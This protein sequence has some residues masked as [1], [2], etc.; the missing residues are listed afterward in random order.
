[1]PPSG[2]TVSRLLGLLYEA[3]ASTRPWST[4]LAAL[5]N[6]TGSAASY[7][8]ILDPQGKC[9]VNLNQGFDP[10]WTHA[11]MTHFNQHD[12]VLS[13]YLAAKRLHGEWIGTRESVIPAEEYFRS[14]IHNEFTKPQGKRYSCAAALGGLDGILDGGL[15]LMRG[16]ADKPFG[17]ETVTLL[18]MLAPH[19]KQA[20]NT[21]RALGLAHC[22]NAE[23][24]ESV[25]ALNLAVL[26]LDKT[27]RVVRMSAAAQAIL[28]LR[29]GIVLDGGFL[30]ASVA[31]EQSQLAAMIAGAV[32][33]GV[34]HG[35]EVAVRRKTST[36]P[37]AGDDP[38]W[39]PSPGGAMVVSRWP[40]SRPLAVI[41]T[42]FHSSELL[43]G[44]QPAALVFFSDP[45]ART[46]LRASVLRGL[47]RLTPTE[48]R[49][50]SL[51][52]EGCELTAA[53]GQMKMTVE[54]ARFHLKAIF[55]K[56]GVSRQAELVR[57]VMGLPNL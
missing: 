36:A 35:E 3:S 52:C 30:R 44:D 21:H 28:D 32:S 34:G 55:R 5:G 15:G 18:T 45:D 19:L 6:S 57:L 16:P 38:L 26:S 7:F 46:E 50:T 27:G 29:S 2:A 39:T 33:T 48:C 42:P 11:Y 51:I 20:L 40:P 10:A 8:L 37:E 47:Y 12:V 17:K 54:T 4:F 43:L 25:E 1:M 13:R 53:A 14:Y 49:L 41:V 23:L 31:A 22:Q 24:Q 56:T 9:N